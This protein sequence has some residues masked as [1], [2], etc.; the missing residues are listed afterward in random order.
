LEDKTAVEEDPQAF[1]EIELLRPINEN[2]DIKWSLNGRKL[3]K[4]AKYGVESNRNKCRL[5]IKDITLEDEG[6][7]AVEINNSKSSAL[8]IVEGLF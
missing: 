8:L 3:E 4:G 5:I 1:F 7:Y 6:T 2:D